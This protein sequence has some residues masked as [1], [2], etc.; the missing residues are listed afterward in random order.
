MD[1]SRNTSVFYPD[2]AEIHIADDIEQERT[3]SESHNTPYNLSMEQMEV[4][5]LHDEV[6]EVKDSQIIGIISNNKGGIIACVICAS[7]LLIIFGM[8]LAFNIHHYSSS[9]DNQQ[10]IEPS[11]TTESPIRS[12]APQTF[13]PATFEPDTVAPETLGPETLAPQTLQPETLSPDTSAPQ[14]LKPETFAPDTLKPETLAPETSAPQTLEPQTFAPAT[15]SPSDNPSKIPSKLPIKS[16]S[17]N[18]TTNS[19]S[20]NPS[21]SPISTAPIQWSGTPIIIGDDKLFLEPETWYECP[22][23]YVMSG[24]NTKYGQNYAFSNLK[25]MKCV[26]PDIPGIDPPTVT[27]S[28]KD[29]QPAYAGALDGDFHARCDGDDEFISGFQTRSTPNSQCDHSF[30][31]WEI[32]RCCKYDNN[33]VRVG[34]AILKTNVNTCFKSTDDRWCEISEPELL[35]DMGI[36]MSQN[37]Y[38]PTMVTNNIES[39]KARKLYF[40]QPYLWG[41]VIGGIS[42]GVSSDPVEWQKFG[43][44]NPDR[45]PIEDI[46]VVGNDQGIQSVRIKV[47]GVWQHKQGASGNAAITKSLGGLQSGEHVKTIVVGAREVGSANY[48]KIVYLAFYTNLRAFYGPSLVIGD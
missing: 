37:Q 7:L 46:E 9:E 27:C 47:D 34:P 10:N 6:Q 11:K 32:L 22:I 31:C 29:G 14:T 25:N 19:P 5:G 18:P 12:L 24:F 42:D 40:K 26:T 4:Q 41:Q 16:P 36:A 13:R 43:E 44:S 17:D 8:S 35:Q 2:P 30:V 38:D 48:R 23:G 1:E 39:F 15:F 28:D 45:K 21:K 33:I 20:E 3:T